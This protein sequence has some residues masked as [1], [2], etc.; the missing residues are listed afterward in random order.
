MMLPLTCE[1]CG[2][3]SFWYPS[4]LHND[5]SGPRRFCS[6]ACRS[7]FNSKHYNT[8]CRW[9][10]G[11]KK[12]IHRMFCSASCRGQYQRAARMK[13]GQKIA[14]TNVKEART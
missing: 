3:T 6:L 7:E 14:K 11:P 2:E 8:P 4:Q 1:S 12:K 13:K 5:K 10:A 9:C